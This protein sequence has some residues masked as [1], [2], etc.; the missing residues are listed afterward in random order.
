LAPRHEIGLITVIYL[1]RCIHSLC[2]YP[3]PPTCGLTVQPRF[4][5][6]AIASDPPPGPHFIDHFVAPTP[7]TSFDIVRLPFCLKIRD[8]L[9]LRS[10]FFG[11]LCCLHALVSSLY[12]PIYCS[13]VESK[14]TSQ[15]V[16]RAIS[17]NT[18]SINKL[19]CAQKKRVSENASFLEPKFEKKDLSIQH[20]QHKLFRWLGS[21]GSIRK[22]TPRKTATHQASLALV[23]LRCFCCRVL[24][25]PVL[26]SPIPTTRC[27]GEVVQL[28][29]PQVAL[30]DDQC[31]GPEDTC[32][33]RGVGVPQDVLYQHPICSVQSGSCG[34][35]FE[36]VRVELMTG[37]TYGIPTISGL[38][39]ATKQFSSPEFAS[40]RYV[41]TGVIIGEFS[42][43]HPKSERVLKALARM[44]YIHRYFPFPFSLNEIAGVDGC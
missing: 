40:K 42:G 39:V 20:G 32:L 38:L 33:R 1:F 44:N 19:P 36:G 15:F 4:S 43:H 18:I 16:P 11:S 17:T 14:R 2:I 21:S 27:H 24:C 13:S 22:T 23:P 31:R 5:G 9:Q 37:Q 3:A 7:R 34:R 8:V 30:E 41:D 25:G 28:S 26:L 10:S 12:L 35:C 29:R 6:S